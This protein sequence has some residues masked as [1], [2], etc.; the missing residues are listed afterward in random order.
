LANLERT[1]RRLEWKASS[2]V[3]SSYGGRSH[4]T[5]DDLAEKERFVARVVAARRAGT[6][7]DLGANDGRFSRVALDAGATGV[8][9]VDSDHLVVDHLYRALE[10]SGERRILPL[11]LDLADPSPSLG[12]RSAERPSFVERVRPDLVLCLAVVHH[13]ALTNTVPFEEIV[14]FLRG[15][16]APLVVEL[17]HRDDPMVQRLLRRKREGLFDHYDR[18][19]WEA[20]LGRA[21]RVLEQVEL[22]RGTR[23]LYHCE[24][25]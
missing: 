14:A 24:P 5:D 16:G 25:A 17:P 21:F 12:W 3:W 22:P 20:E 4:Y 7:L 11:V 13:L 8:V 19:P 2:S 1:V 10:A 18:G 15:F 23:T 9:A 6:V